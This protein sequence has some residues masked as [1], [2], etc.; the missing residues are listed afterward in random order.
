VSAIVAVAEGLF[1]GIGEEAHL[2][3]T[4]C[5]SCGTYYFPRS[6]SCRNPYCKDKLL[7]HVP[8]SRHGRLYSYTCQHYRPPPVFRRDIWSP[9]ALGVIE[10]PEQIRIIAMLA[11]VEFPALSVNLAMEL[12][13]VPLYQDEQ[14]RAVTTYAF[15]PRTSR[16]PSP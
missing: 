13:L 1:V 15:R 4:H 3:G 9:Y 6:L 8:L 7:E 16:Q 14:G 12:I 11:E 2:L 5:R 10:L